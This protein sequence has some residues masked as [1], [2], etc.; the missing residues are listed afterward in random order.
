MHPSGKY[1]Y[2]AQNGL[3]PAKYQRYNINADTI[4]DMYNASE[5]DYGE[6]LWIAD[7]GTKFFSRYGY[8]YSCN[9]DRSLDM[10]RIGNLNCQPCIWLAQSN[11]ADC[12]ALL[13]IPDGSNISF[14]DQKI[15]GLLGTL[16]LAALAPVQDG[17]SR[18][19]VFNFFSQDGNACTVLFN[20]DSNLFSAYTINDDQ[21]PQ[22]RD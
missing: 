8:V 21:Y 10:A 20:A 12:I 11:K 14:Y 17:A 6:N 4:T 5:G 7:D 9:P 2:G 3:S 16:S 18:K 1:I 19:A 22:A 13:P 15:Y